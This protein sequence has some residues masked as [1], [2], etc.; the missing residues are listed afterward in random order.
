MGRGGGGG[1]ISPLPAC[2]P[3]RQGLNLGGLPRHQQANPKAKLLFI[4]GKQIWLA[5]FPLWTAGRI[6]VV[7]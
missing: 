2:W 7:E 1:T 5:A 4:A 3:N 6:L